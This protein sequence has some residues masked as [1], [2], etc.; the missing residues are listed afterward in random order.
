MSNE[1][2]SLVVERVNTILAA[3]NQAVLPTNLAGDDTLLKSEKYSLGLIG[4]D[5][6]AIMELFLVIEQDFNVD[7]VDDD[8]SYEAVGTLGH[9]V[10][11]VDR[12]LEN[13]T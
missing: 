11:Y 10:D 6:Q 13:V 1:T 5:S 2:T 8:L 3:N 9:L 12:K 4:L 7:L